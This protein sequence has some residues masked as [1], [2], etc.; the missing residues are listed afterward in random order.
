[1]A[2]T[3]GRRRIGLIEDQLLGR[4]IYDLGEIAR[5]VQRSPAEVSTWARS[6]ARTD[7]LLFPR[8]SRLFAFPDLVTAVV[9]AELRGRDVRLDRIRH[10]RH[11]LATKVESDWPLAHFAAL[12]ELATSGASVYVGSKRDWLDASEGGQMAFYEVASPLMRRLEFGRDGLATLWRPVD[13]I[14][15]NPAIQ[16]GAPCVEG[17]R[18]STEFL[19]ELE[20]VGEEP[21]DIAHDYDL[22]IALVS[23]ALRYEHEHRTAA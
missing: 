18:I 23:Q 17:T 10:A 15:V 7:A 8:Q 4:G 9:V 5:L 16:A 21:E 11:Y 19:A 6:T 22:D 2:K 20:F 13:G 12:N 3:K 1:M 14:V